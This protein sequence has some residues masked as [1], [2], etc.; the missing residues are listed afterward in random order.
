[1]MQGKD[2]NYK[3]SLTKIRNGHFSDVSSN[4]Q[5]RISETAIS[6]EEKDARKAAIR[7]KIRFQLK[8]LLLIH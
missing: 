1:M 2:K 6:D 5:N 3:I 8:Q 7:A 4:S